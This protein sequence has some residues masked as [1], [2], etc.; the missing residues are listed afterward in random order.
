MDGK[1]FFFKQN[2]T[3]SFKTFQRVVVERRENLHK[4]SSEIGVPSH[5]EIIKLRAGEGHEKVAMSR[6]TKPAKP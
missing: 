2:F 4:I 5:K 6:S 1:L 3:P